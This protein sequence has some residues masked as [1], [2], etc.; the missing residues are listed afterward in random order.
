MGAAG[1]GLLGHE[2]GGG[3]LGTIGGALV[4]AIGAN[5]LE[6]RHERLVHSFYLSLLIIFS[7]GAIKT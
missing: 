4:G 3:S 1:G 2:I 5:A 7:P 6:K